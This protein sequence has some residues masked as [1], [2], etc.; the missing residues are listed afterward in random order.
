MK[1]PRELLEQN[2]IKPTLEVKRRR[3]VVKDIKTHLSQKHDIFDGTIQTWINNPA[4]E[5]KN[6]DARLLYLFSQQIYEK[7]GDLNIN[8]EEFFTDAEAKTSKQYSGKMF[9]KEELKFPLIFDYALE[10]SR[11]SWIVM[12]D[13]KTIAGLLKSRKLHWNPEAQREATIKEVNGEIVETATVY[14]HNVLEMKQ[15]LK[16]N[17]LERTQLIFNASLGTAD[18]NGDEVVFD[19]ETKQLQINNCK[20]DVIDGYHR[21]LAAQLALEESPDIDFMFEVKILNFTTPRSASFLAQI[22]K[23]ERMSE[24]K[25][26][27]MSKETFTDIIIDE[28]R[29]K[30]ALRNR[31]PNK[32]GLRG[33]DLVTYN[34]LKESINKN[35]EIKRKLDQVEVS[36][37]L[38]EFFD[39]L[40]EFYDTEFNDNFKETKEKSLLVENVTFAGYIILAANM[41]SND[42]DPSQ[43]YKY[44]K[45]I[46]FSKDNSVW[47]EYDV[48]DD[49]NRLTRNAKQGIEKYFSNLEI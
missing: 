35:F 33:R 17:K 1:Q 8:P 31:I 3:G 46:D 10:S 49:K 36:D 7:T 44:L 30:S 47:K 24:V 26:R 19:K 22:S 5:L 9:L 27:S 11:D 21:C 43:V 12:M 29:N 41:K 18:D 39:I 32:E 6:I 45:K 40:I 13:I 14:M 2:L 16:E 15:L 20:M 38:K 4:E 48:L 42:I 34:T 37:Y 25:R 23:G 28:L